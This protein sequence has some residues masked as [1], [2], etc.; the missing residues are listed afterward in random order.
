M[1]LFFGIASVLYVSKSTNDLLFEIAVEYETLKVDQVRSV[2]QEARYQ[3]LQ[4]KIEIAKEDKSFFMRSLRL[5]AGI[6]TVMM[7]YGFKKWHTEVQPIQD[8]IVRL[9]LIKLEREVGGRAQHT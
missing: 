3:I 6:G 1:L 4:K 7:W 5:I 8:E 9:N 2:P